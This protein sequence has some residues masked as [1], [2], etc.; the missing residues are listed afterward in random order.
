[1]TRRHRPAPFIDHVLTRDHLYV[2]YGRGEVQ[3]AEDLAAYEFGT[4]TVKAAD[5]FKAGRLAEAWHGG[6]NT[7]LCRF[8]QGHWDFET[9]RTAMAELSAMVADAERGG[10]EPWAARQALALLT[11]ICTFDFGG[12]GGKHDA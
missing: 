3:T 10:S 5:M 7:G 11:R 1:M 12:P 4:L 9:V 6:V 8:S 2:R